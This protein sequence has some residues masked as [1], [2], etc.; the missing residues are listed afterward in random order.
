MESLAFAEKKI[1]RKELVTGIGASFLVHVLVFSSAFI[2]AWV[3][4][5]TTFEA[6]LLHG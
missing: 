4:P 3:M 6:S 2:L 5:H 1:P